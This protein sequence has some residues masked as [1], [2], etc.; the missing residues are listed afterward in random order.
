[1]VTTSPFAIVQTAVAAIAP[2]AGLPPEI[3]RMIT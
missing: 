3:V 2:A 1:M